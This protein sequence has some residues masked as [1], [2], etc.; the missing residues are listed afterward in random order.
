MCDLTPVFTSAADKRNCPRPV[1]HF[2]QYSIELTLTFLYP[3]ELREKS[4]FLP[5][6]I[7]GYVLCIWKTIS[8][9]SNKKNIMTCIPMIHMATLRFCSGK[10]I[11]HHILN[12]THLHWTA[13]QNL[14]CVYSSWSNVK[15]ARFSTFYISIWKEKLIYTICCNLKLIRK[16]IV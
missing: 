9:H 16:R 1:V 10:S 14:E 4:C 2:K 3:R 12:S 8:I 6:T 13:F 7:M 15:K 11:T 5:P